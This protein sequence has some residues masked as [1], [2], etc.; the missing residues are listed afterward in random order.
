VAAAQ[1]TDEEQSLKNNKRRDILKFR[2]ESGKGRQNFGL[3]RSK[4]KCVP[5][6]GKGSASGKS[7]EGLRHAKDK[8]PRYAKKERGRVLVHERPVTFE[9]A[10]SRR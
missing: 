1:T 6:E 9:S 4:K 10:K 8:R 3:A 7:G 5:V 2:V